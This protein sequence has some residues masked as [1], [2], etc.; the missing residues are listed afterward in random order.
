MRARVL[1]N[2]SICNQHVELI[3][4]NGEHLYITIRRVNL[5]HYQGRSLEVSMGQNESRSFDIKDYPQIQE[6]LVSE[7]FKVL[8]HLSFEGQFVEI[9]SE[10]L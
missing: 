8:K 10:L 4:E 9:P 3:L 7:D 1:D 6:E 2:K 5:E